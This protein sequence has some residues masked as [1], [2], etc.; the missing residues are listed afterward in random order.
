MDASKVVHAAMNT[1]EIDLGLDDFYIVCR[2]G[3]NN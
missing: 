3:E 2:V 1:G